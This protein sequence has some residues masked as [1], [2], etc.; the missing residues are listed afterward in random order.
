MKLWM[1][2]ILACPEC[3]DYPLALKA[4]SVKDKPIKKPEEW[5]IKDYETLLIER[6]NGILLPNALDYVDGCI[7][8]LMKS[9]IVKRYKQFFECCDSES[10]KVASDLLVFYDIEVERGTLTCRKC[11]RT[12]PIGNHVKGVPELLPDELRGKD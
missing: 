12:Y 4:E 11:G 2:N 7:D 9:V 1:L 5:S 8:P 10:A 3:K 6:E